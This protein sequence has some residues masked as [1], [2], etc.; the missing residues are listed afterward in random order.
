M[1]KVW[2]AHG[3]P[4]VSA[5][6][7]Q[8]NGCA[9]SSHI[10]KDSEM[11]EVHQ[12][13]EDVCF[14]LVVE[15]ETPNFTNV[16][17]R[18]KEYEN[19]QKCPEYNASRYKVN[20]RIG[21]IKEGISAKVLRY[22]PILPRIQRMFLLVDSQS[23]T[24]GGN[25]HGGNGD[26][27][28]K[29]TSNPANT[30]QDGPKNGEVGIHSSPQTGTSK[31]VQGSTIC[32]ND[33]CEVLDWDAAQ[34]A[35]FLDRREAGSLH[36]VKYHSLGNNFILVDNRDSSDPK[37]TPEQA[38]RLCDRNFGIGADGVIFTLPG[39]NDTDYTM[40]IFNSNGSEPEMCGNGVRCFARFITE[41]ENLHGKQRFT[42]HTGAGL[43]V[44]EIADDGKVFAF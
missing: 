2:V 24:G 28:N 20:L 8:V 40:R 31:S 6:S 26:G 27:G 10:N 7:A 37:F 19:L 44:P 1:Y 12:M 13:Y 32:V 30:A 36:F 41:I 5:R 16:E 3:E 38:V 34:S 11:L 18:G 15:G 25:G 14:Q 9:T 33:L 4:S 35:S 22:F 39:I 17:D 23:A 43:I 21:K 29:R 42:V